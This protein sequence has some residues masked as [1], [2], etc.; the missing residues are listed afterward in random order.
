MKK[1]KKMATKVKTKK[2]KV[3]KTTTAVI[4]MI[5]KITASKIMMKP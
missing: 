4:K 3:I 5:T 1:M 2:K